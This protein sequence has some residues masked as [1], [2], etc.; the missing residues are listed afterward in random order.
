[1]GAGRRGLLTLGAGVLALAATAPSGPV[2]RAA[3]VPEVAPYFETTGVHTGNLATAISGHGLRSF[4]TAFVLGKGCTPTWDDNSPLS[5]ATAKNALVTKAKAMG[6]VPII[7]FGGQA[8]KELAISCTNQSSLV[9]AYTSVIQRFGVTKIDFDV[10]GAAAVNNTAANT[11]RYLAI[12]A[13]RQRYPSLEVSFTLGVGP[14]GIEPNNQYSGDGM[15]LLRLAKAKGVK[16]DVVNIMTM[17]YGA[18]EPDMGATAISSADHTVPQLKSIWGSSFGYDHLGITPMIGQND[19]PGETFSYA[20][21]QNV[22]AYARS[23]GVHRLAFWSLNRDQQCGPGETAP[24]ACTGLA[25]SPL[26]YT[27]AFLG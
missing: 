3:T 9:A 10:E 5:S 8:G 26:D 18:A 6:A 15:A 25:Q 2:A 19:S 20:D 1:M 16:I 14:D 12:K 13:L 7:S 23:K 17:D 27:D 22:V 4:S 24:A 21:A 11:R